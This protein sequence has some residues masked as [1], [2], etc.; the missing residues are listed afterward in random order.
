MADQRAPK[1]NHQ[2]PASAHRR[3]CPVQVS[4]TNHPVELILITACECSLAD[5]GADKENKSADHEQ[6][7]DDSLSGVSSVLTFET[8]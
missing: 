6:A 2:L 1:R 7:S 5:G 8:L 3:V 4:S